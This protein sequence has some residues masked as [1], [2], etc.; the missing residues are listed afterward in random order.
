[1]Q[2]PAVAGAQ[3]VGVRQPGSGDLAVAYVLAASE[4]FDEADVAAYCKSAMAAF[5]QPFRI[6][7]ID[8]FPSMNGPNGKK[9]QKRVLR[10]MAA[11][12]VATSMT[13]KD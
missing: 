12:L 1:M 2:H 11:Q 3:V 10:E 9:I 4:D 7:R 5:K 13:E 8:E 6:V